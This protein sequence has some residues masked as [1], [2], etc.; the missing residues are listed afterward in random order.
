MPSYD[1]RKMVIQIP[2][3]SQNSGKDYNHDALKKLIYFFLYLY[4]SAPKSNIFVEN[5]KKGRLLKMI[6]EIRC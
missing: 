5:N 4:S 2:V 3:N 1:W 6:F